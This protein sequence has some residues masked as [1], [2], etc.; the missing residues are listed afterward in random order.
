MTPER[1]LICVRSRVAE[2]ILGTD[3]VEPRAS[4]P[5]LGEVRL[6]A[7]Q[8]AAAG[9]L[10][11]ILDARGG[12]LLANR[13][14]SG[15]T[16]VALAVATRYRR[17]LVVA[18][19]ALRSVWAGAATRTGREIA[20]ASIESLSAGREPAVAKP[21][22]VIIDEAHHVRSPTTRRYRALTQLCGGARV[23]LLSA[24]PVQNRRS[25][26]V[27]QLALF[28]GSDAAM[29][30]DAALGALVVRQGPDEDIELPRVHGPV[31]L[32]PPGEDDI[33]DELLAL[34]PP[35]PALDEGTAATLTSYSLLHLWASSRAALLQSLR[36]RR[37][38]AH[39]MR[40]ALRSGRVP[41]RDEL[42]AWT[43]D[44]ASVQLAFADLILAA[45]AGTTTAQVTAVERYIAAVTALIRRIRQSP[46]PDIA[47]AALLDRVRGA[48]PGARVVAFSQYAETVA[49]IAGALPS[50]NGVAVMTAQGGRIASGSISRSEILAQLDP[51]HPRSRRC[52]RA[53]RIDLLLTTDV[54]SE[55]VDLHAASVVVHLDLP[56]N[57]ARLEQR[58][59]RICRPGAPHEVAHVY[60]LMPPAATERI[61][62]VEHRLRAK[63]AVAGRTVG[64]IAMA[65]H[66]DDLDTRSSA[67]DAIERMRRTAAAWRVDD[68]SCAGREIAGI[69]SDVDGIVAVVREGG[70]QGLIGGTDSRLGDDPRAL[71]PLVDRLGGA[72]IHVDD[73]LAKRAVARVEQALAERRG[74][75][76]ASG[77][78]SSG[79]ARRAVRDRIRSSVHRAPRHDRAERVALAARA[80]ETVGGRLD[81][82]AERRL[83]SLI[84]AHRGD[85]DAWL[86]SIIA[87][88]GEGRD[89]ASRQRSGADVPSAEGS[90][91][92][93]AVL[94]ADRGER[95]CTVARI[96]LLPQLVGRR[97]VANP[98]RASVRFSS[99]SEPPWASTI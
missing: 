84:D 79:R 98:P 33:M 9:R 41:S 24:T 99:V 87:F 30:D 66:G 58:V 20:F 29:L 22:L 46:D 95:A 86:R 17:V 85:D 16:Y 71:A 52:P 89:D 21:D 92:A 6:R 81:A 54:L 32:H 51:A 13:V 93:V 55:G 50:R 4:E 28:L 2:A 61:V 70:S 25:D 44:G 67:A 64:P 96:P 69:A 18:P 73:V 1:A 60:L 82:A 63:L 8:L 90:L 36:R 74:R 68:G 26:L 5:C 12:A 27:T 94:I 34:P 56:W 35:V 57:P 91:L 49:A 62:Q 19:A 45:P 72:A 42:A 65:L 80:L 40:D 15:K 53:E 11:T 31:P 48:H 39:A 88:F 83:E 78:V 10:R 77:S 43:F 97:I 47:R 7:Q 76:L 59:G 3:P 23:L 37:A 38:R 14:G 75:Q